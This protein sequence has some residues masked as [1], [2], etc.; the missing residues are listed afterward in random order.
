MLPYYSFKAACVRASAAVLLSVLFPICSV[1]ASQRLPENAEKTTWH[2]SASKLTYDDKKEIYTAENNV[3]ITGG[4]TRLEADYVEFSNRTKDAYAAGSVL[5]VSGG[6]TVTC[7]AVFINLETREGTIYR[8][9]IF[10]K[11]NN[12]YIR[13]NQI[14]KEGEDTYRADKAAITTC[15]GENP[16]WKISATDVRVTIE[17]YG[18]A[19][20]ATFWAENVPALYTPYIV[21]PAKTE[22]QTG[23]LAPRISFS[24]RQGFEF[25]QPFFVA[26]AEN[27]DATI[28]IDYMGERGVKTGLEYRYVLDSRSKGALLFDFLD[29]RKIDDGTP[30]TSDYSFDATPRRTNSDRYWIR[31]KADQGL[32]FDVTA[33]LDIDIVSDADYLHEFKEGVTGFNAANEYFESTFGRSLDDYDDTTRRNILHLNRSWEAHSL[34]IDF[35]W[36]DEIEDSD[37]T[38]LQ[39]LPGVGFYAAKQRIGGT[40][41][42]YTMDSRLDYFYREETTDMLYRGKRADLHPTVSVPLKIDRHLYMEPSVG[43]RQTLWWTETFGALSDEEDSSFHRE[44]YDLNF[45][46][47]SQ[48]DNVFESPFA[49]A[50]KIKHDIIPEIAYTYIPEKDQSDLPLFEY[51]ADSEAIPADDD[52][53]DRIDQENTVTWSLTNRLTSRKTVRQ[54]DK[55]RHAYHEF[56]WIKLYQHYYIDTEAAEADRQDHAF[57]DIFLES[58]FNPASCLSLNADLSWSPYDNRLTSYE[59]G[60]TLRDNRGDWLYAEYRGEEADT[61]TDE[62]ET[63]YGKISVKITEK[64]RVYALHEADLVSD[65]SVETTAGVTVTGPCWSFD[66]SFTE[67]Q[68]ETEIAFLVTLHG[69]GEFGTK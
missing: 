30:A 61:E 18:M 29:D 55:N 19:R 54:K 22:R 58:E 16:D 62:S 31:G 7:D 60:V 21:F 44:L 69:L 59:T 41:L 9:T 68:D 8:G 38:S 40:P 49:S 12:F 14:V 2:I 3:V 63:V 27:Q 13:G 28:N 24:D 34:N 17:G 1:S 25:E 6:D 5:L 42:F 67:T 36:Y 51:D 37:N 66:T 57:S 53:I 4:E 50:E 48:L 23:L 39:R 56:A 65:E 11:K 33:R 47:S 32:W 45:R 35:A 43:V 26:I 64:L 46:V 15:S 20:N 52:A 10:I